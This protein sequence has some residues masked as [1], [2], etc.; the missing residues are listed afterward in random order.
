MPEINTTQDIFQKDYISKDL[1]NIYDAYGS[2]F[3]LMDNK[4]TIYYDE[5]GDVSIESN[6]KDSNAR[7]KIL[8]FAAHKDAILIKITGEKFFSSFFKEMVTDKNHYENTAQEIR[9]NY[10][11][12]LAAEYPIEK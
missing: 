1:K 12:F 2:A 5:K 3:K 6:I 10:S 4:L 8:K 7:I 9:D 11:K